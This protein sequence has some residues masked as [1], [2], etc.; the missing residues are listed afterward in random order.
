[1][2]AMA[3][4][5]GL[6]RSKNSAKAPGPVLAGFLEAA[7]ELDAVLEGAVHALAVKGHDG[8]R[9]V[10]EQQQPAVEV[11]GLAAHRA[12]QA[13]RVGE[14]SV[15][16]LVD[17]AARRRGTRREEVAHGPWASSRLA[18]DGSPSTAAGTASP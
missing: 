6:R 2:S 1:M 7:I 3:S 12:E 10:A 18:K 9:G 13:G 8:V 16:E 15:L 11:P 14:G 17:H 4:A 5:F